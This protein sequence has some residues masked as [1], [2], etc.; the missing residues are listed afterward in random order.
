MLKD[1][2]EDLQS[3]ADPTKARSLQR[4]FKTNK[5]Q[6]GEGDVF[7]GISM[8]Q[9]R[10][11]IKY[12]NSLNF[13]EL[14]ELLDSEFH[15]YR[16]S[17]LLILVIQ[18][19][20][21]KTEKRKEIYEFYIKNLQRINNWDLVDCTCRD[22]VGAYLFDKDR[23]PLYQLAQIDH[24]WSQRVAIVSTWYF[25]REKQYDDT[26]KISEMLLNHN[27]DLIHKA[28]G[29]MLREAWKKT[30]SHQVEDF[31]EK[32]A[33]TMPRTALRYTIERMPE[34]TRQ[35]FMKL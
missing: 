29:W 30:G 4:F 12:H 11:V 8:P 21:A 35:Y 18:F 19:K 14:Q 28:V 17:A 5:G 25:I 10:D 22:I 24:L 27:H 34:P 9:I 2:I 1:L 6:Y 15:E 31:L 13:S 23:S 33:S 20:K 32:Y 7:I 26:L 16:M 3:I